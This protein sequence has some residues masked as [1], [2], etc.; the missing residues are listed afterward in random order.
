MFLFQKNHIDQIQKETKTQ[1]RRNHKRARARV[2]AIHQCRTEL[3]G[4]PHC[5]I[6]MTRVWTERLGAI[7]YADAQAEGGYHQEEYINGLI[8]MHKGKLTRS[9]LLWCYEFELVKEARS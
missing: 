1:T 7:S 8:E 2:G 3:F 9:S 6:R 5:H 4:K